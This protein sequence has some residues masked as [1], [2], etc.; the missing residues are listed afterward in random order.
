MKKTAEEKRKLK[1]QER[2]RL[3]LIQQ[4]QDRRN[5]LTKEELE[6]DDERKQFLIDERIKRNQFLKD[7]QELFLKSKEQKLKEQ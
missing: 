1:Q 5:R 3:Q 4:E 7:R 6:A 2:F